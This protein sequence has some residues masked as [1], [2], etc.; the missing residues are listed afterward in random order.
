[1]RSG[2]RPLLVAVAVLFML[3]GLAGI[4]VGGPSAAAGWWMLIVGAALLVGIMLERPRYGADRDAAQSGG[5][6]LRPTDE[7][8]VDP[9]TGQRTRVW[10]DPTSGERD[11][12]PE[13][14]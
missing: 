6:R 7:I 8:F 1:M 5:A 13:T 12:R 14:D 3:S 9:T 2:L 11:Y 4:A 10:A